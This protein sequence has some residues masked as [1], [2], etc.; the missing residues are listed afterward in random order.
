MRKI[1]KIPAWLGV[2]LGFGL[3]ASSFGQVIPQRVAP[4][5]I[6]QLPFS[7][8]G[9][10]ETKVGNS[11][12]QGSGAIA[13]DSRLVFTC[14]HVAFDRGIWASS[15]GIAPGWSSRSDAS[16]YIPLRGWRYFS[17]YAS[18]AL[19]DDS[20]AET[21]NLD[22]L[23]GYRNESIGSVVEARERGADYLT[24][25]N[26]QKMIVGYPSSRD[27]D[28]VSGFFFMHQTGPFAGGFSQERDAYHGF[29]GASTGNGNSGGP[30][31]ENSAGRWILAGILVSGT[32]NSIGVYAIDAGAWQLSTNALESLGANPAG[33]PDS[34]ASGDWTNPSYGIYQLLEQRSSLLAQFTQARRIKNPAARQIQLRRLR[35]MLLQVNAQIAALS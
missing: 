4:G 30:V 20:S 28:G 26:V 23:V 13:R 16:T 10:I 35:T 19:T 3:A 11:F 24:N 9:L 7:A 17:G 14:A 18:A 25:G 5:A 22:F 27:F 2:I 31:F 1:G 33:T 6:G 29:F 8:T 21:F 12:Y 32:R 15:I 34:A